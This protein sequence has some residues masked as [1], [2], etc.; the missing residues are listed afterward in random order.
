MLIS[1]H[2]PKF[3][4]FDVALVSLGHCWLECEI[5][6]IVKLFQV[7]DWLY[8]WIVHLSVL[9]YMTWITVDKK[10]NNLLVLG[11]WSLNLI[12]LSWVGGP[13][14]APV[15]K[16]YHKVLVESE[17]WINSLPLCANPLEMLKPWGWSRCL[18]ECWFVPW[19]FSCHGVLP[20]LLSMCIRVGDLF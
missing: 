1:S 19:L 9:T 7:S 17:S 5:N 6:P 3:P 12:R 11:I 10:H 13:L 14:F 2:I 16:F 8:F 20:Q 18:R 15:F 4:W